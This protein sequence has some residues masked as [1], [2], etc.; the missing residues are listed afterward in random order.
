MDRSSF[1]R[2]RKPCMDGTVSQALPMRRILFPHEAT[3]P[4]WG[5]I[6]DCGGPREQ[7]GPHAQVG[8]RI[9]PEC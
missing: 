1:Q 5:S 4:A 8:V 2:A 9:T 7:L 3:A 6:A